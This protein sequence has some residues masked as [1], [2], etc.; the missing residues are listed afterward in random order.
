MLIGNESKVRLSVIK[1]PSNTS[2]ATIPEFTF[3]NCS[4]YSS[5]E[6]CRS[7]KVC[8]W[9]SD[10]CSSI[11]TE[12]SSTQCPSFNLI[13]PSNLY[14]E[15]GQSIEIPLKFSNTIKSL[16]ECRLNETIIGFIDENNI[17]QISKVPEIVSENNQIIFFSIYENNISIGIPIK[18]FIYR[19][20]LY[21]SC[22]QCQSHLTCSWCQGKCLSKK[23]KQ[24]LINS[25]CTSLKIEDF[26]PKFLP[27][28]GET[29]VKISLNQLINE[30]I[31]E[32]TLADILCLIIKKS[33]NEIECLSKQSNSSRQGLI[34]ISF[35]NF[36]II[37]SKEFIEYRQSSIISF[38]PLIIYE[39][40]GQILHIN[41]NNLIIGNFQQI[42]I[43]N[44]QCL[45]IKQIL[46]NS[47]TCRLPSISSGV[48]NVTVIIDKQ[49][50]LNNGIV[51]TVTPNPIVQDINP[52]ISFAR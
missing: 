33:I 46:I 21:E 37:Y 49:T 52:L 42:F 32:I 3:Y 50:I 10:R 48:Y 19:C 29:L 25:R 39:F 47:L 13:D 4:S 36:I 2:I 30:K 43:G 23:T 28:N 24:C 12:K 14:I 1:Y 44:F 20:D 26:S 41:G 9:C 51:L 11:C 17:C 45:I 22:D 18:M 31:I 27:L 34:K 40:G 8:Q 16:L 15:S 7:E 6:S 35:E 5:C 38:N